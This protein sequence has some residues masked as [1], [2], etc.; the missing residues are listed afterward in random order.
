MRENKIIDLSL[1]P[2]CRSSLVL[3]LNRCNYVACI[4]KA[5]TFA[6]I[7][8]P[9]PFQYGWTAEY[10]I[11]WHDEI[12]PAELDELFCYE[13]GKE[14]GDESDNDYDVGPDEESESSDKDS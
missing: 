1:L 5:S 9:N 2:P 8:I 13:S 11:Q 4:W 3:H 12:F 14:S 6:N 7:N 10:E